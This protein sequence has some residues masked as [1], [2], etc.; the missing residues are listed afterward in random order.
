MWDKKIDDVFREKVDR[1]KQKVKRKSEDRAA[2]SSVLDT[3]T[4][5]TLNK[6]LN[7]RTIRE[8]IGVISAGKEATVYLGIHPEEGEV[9]I[10]IYKIDTQTSKWMA[11]YLKGDHRFK[12]MGS[13]ITKLIYTWTLKEFRNL[14]RAFKGGILVPKPIL[15]KN[16][17][18]VMQFIGQDGTPAPK[19]KDVRELDDPTALF[20]E[21]L[22]IITRLYQECD[23]VHGDFSEFNILYYDRKLVPIDMGQGVTS[24]HPKSRPYLLRDLKNTFTFFTSWGVAV[25]DLE[26]TYYAIVGDDER[27]DAQED[28]PGSY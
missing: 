11:E 5:F 17:V 19:L 10:K 24:D 9:G 6:L 15:A 1:R 27:E 26:E 22:D 14:S 3:R 23:L 12:K 21:A 16:N 20:H 2:V 8:L 7:Q 4:L 13:N 18:L 25:P 28:D